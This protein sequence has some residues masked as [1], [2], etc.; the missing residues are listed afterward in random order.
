MLSGIREWIA[1]KEFWLHLKYFIVDVSTSAGTIVN[2]NANIMLSKLNTSHRYFR[3][4]PKIRDEVSV[5]TH[6]RDG[7]D[8]M[9]SKD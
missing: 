8:K 1:S 5:V 9:R 6:G 2:A 3:L 4:Y 7:L